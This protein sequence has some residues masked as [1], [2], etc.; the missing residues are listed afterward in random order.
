MIIT[1]DYK[2]S[3]DQKGENKDEINIQEE[4]NKDEDN[5]KDFFMTS[6]IDSDE[7]FVMKSLNDL[8][9]TEIII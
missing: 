1:N 9:E 7:E 4:K 6:E 3:I 5:I 8:I 2:Y